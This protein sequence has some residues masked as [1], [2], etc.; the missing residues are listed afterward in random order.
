MKLSVQHLVRHFG[1][2]KA[3]DDVSFELN[4]GEVFGF[5]G[6]NGA[7]KTTAMRIIATLDQPDAGDVFCDGKSVLEYP[8]SARKIIGY[9]PDS[10]PQNQDILVWEYLDFFV[11]AAGFKGPERLRRR[12]E[13]EEFTQLG[14]L[15]D[16]EINKLSKGM[17]Q[18][19]CLARS[20]VHEPQILVMDE[21]AAGLDPRARLELRQMIRFLA[22]EGKAILISSHILSELEDI[23]NGAIIIEQGKIL[24]SGRLNDMYQPL[25]EALLSVR[26]AVENPDAVLPL[27][28]ALAQV[29]SARLAGG[30]IEFTVAGDVKCVSDTVGSLISQTVTVRG[31]AIT[32]HSLE[33]VFMKVTK[34]KVQ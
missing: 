28:H 2:V 6:P 29:K 22:G 23:C 10:L 21:P 12:R 7:G 33:E 27:L 4:S 18:R 11:R 31:F 20:L 9:M 24:S 17:K 14:D 32:D 16:K 8:E 1:K 5:I 25:A 30:G 26:L 19:V 15:R 13:I 34:G 3:L